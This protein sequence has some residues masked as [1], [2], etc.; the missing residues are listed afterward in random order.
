MFSSRR[1]AELEAR[2]SALDCVQAIIEFDLDG[3]ILAANQ[4]FLDAM[5]YT[6]AEIVGRHHGIFVAPAYRES[7]EY[8]DFWR[9]L[10]AGSFEAAQ[11][12]RLGKGGKEV[13]IEASYNPV[14]GRDGKPCRVV[15]FA[16][17]IT[18]QKAETS[19]RE[20][21]IAAIRKSQAV[22]EFTLDGIIL[23]ANANFLAT[24]GYSLD[25]I[26][27]KHH[28]M[29]VDPAYR[30]SAEYASFWAKLAR[31]EYQAAQY[32]RIGKG[33]RG[34]WIQAS[35][36]RIL[37]AS[38]RPYKVV[39]FATD[40]TEQT[41]LLERLRCMI[42]ENFAEIDQAVA[43][44]GHESEAALQASQAT[45]QAVQVTAA[46]SGQLAASVAEVSATMA[47]SKAATDS[48]FVQ[49]ASAGE[50]TKRLS[51]ATEAMT[52]IV[53][54]IQNITSQINLLALNATIES[55]RAGEAGRG[56]A[57]VAQEVK[58]LANQAAKAAEQITGEIGGVQAIS[59]NVVGALDSIRG[60]IDAMRGHV[61]ATAASVDEQTTVTRDMS[62]GM[63]GTARDVK[64][65]ADNITA[66]AS[67]VKQV[68]CAVATT[69]EA[70]KVLAR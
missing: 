10:R 65:I 18:R 4:N 30:A 46:A 53:N 57:V 23:D 6:L 3:R 20:G 14:M 43:H 7:A 56:F 69:R 21:Q 36:N 1:V 17:D 67:A 33:G 41:T 50:F 60:S 5:G 48:A 38:G 39:K 13:W 64:A 31:G 28:A 40:I 29:F 8:R 52:G 37:D 9:R 27:G 54:L 70:A 35:Y 32:R 2:F 15:K 44:S 63:Q 62:A 55:A 24:V 16:T 22:I 68:S 51:E 26:K 11:Y 25:E 49:A 12:K 61:A 42:D 59:N 34:V 47:K 19:D 66:I 58:N 45:A